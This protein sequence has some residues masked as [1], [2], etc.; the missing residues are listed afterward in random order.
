MAAKMR[1]SSDLWKNL[2]T[3]F[4]L[5]IDDVL[6]K[7]LLLCWVHFVT[8][9]ELHEVLLNLFAGFLDELCPQ[10]LNDQVRKKCSS[11]L[12]TVLVENLKV[13]QPNF[14]AMLCHDKTRLG[15]QLLPACDPMTADHH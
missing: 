5:H 8:P 13:V 7:L 4:T 11:L 2:T 15:H 3:R 1:L 6:Q 14:S 12:L 9:Y 10:E